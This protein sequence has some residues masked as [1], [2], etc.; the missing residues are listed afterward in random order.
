MRL[1][2]QGWPS[3]WPDLSDLFGPLD[4]HIANLSVR[5]LTDGQQAIIRFT[6]DYGVE[7]YKYPAA[8]YFELTVIKFTERGISDYEFASNT[9]FPDLNLGYKDE[10][11]FKLCEQ[12]SRLK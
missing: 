1:E 7:I 2:A 12:V 6:N 11:I 10:D 4:Q 8:D 9:P 5:P 3:T